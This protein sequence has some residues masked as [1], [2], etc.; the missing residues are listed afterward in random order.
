MS[1]FFEKTG[2][3]LLVALL[4]V[5]SLTVACIS[6][7]GVGMLLVSGQYEGRGSLADEL[8]EQQMQ[9]D[10]WSI[11][12][13][14]FDPNEPTKPWVSYY[15]GGIYT[16][17]NSNFRYNI[18]DDETGYSVLATVKGGESIRLKRQYHHSFENEYEITV[19]D[20]YTVRSDAISCEGTVYFY[21]EDQNYF[22]PVEDERVSQYVTGAV[23]LNAAVMDEG[24]TYLPAPEYT[25]T[26]G[27]VADVTTENGTYAHFAY[28]GYG[29]FAT[30]FASQYLNEVKDY[31]I[32]CYVLSDLSAP[33]SYWQIYDFA[34]YLTGGRYQLAAVCAVSLLAGVLL[35]ILLGCYVGRVAGAE[36]PV[37]NIIFRLPTDIL[38]L[39]DFLCAVVCVDMIVQ[40]VP[41][42]RFLSA[43]VAACVFLL[44]LALL[45]VYS[46]CSLSARGKTHTL[47]SGSAIYWCVKHVK[48]LAKWLG[49][50]AARVLG[51]MPLLWKVGVCYGVL[52]FIEFVWLVG[53]SYYVDGATV[54]M[55]LLERL[56]LGVL[57][58]YVTLAFRRLK[59][60]A[61]SIAAGDYTTKIS[62]AHLVLDFKETA[63]TLNHIQDGMNAAVDSRMKSERLKTELITNV[64]HDIKTPLTSIVSYVDLLKK[65]PMTTEAAKEYLSVLER[66]SARLKKLVEDL[67]EAS[68]ASTGNIAVHAESMDISVVLGQ[69]LGEYNERLLKIGLTPVV[70]VPETPVMVS[71][72][73]RLLW[74]VFDNLLGNAV[75]Y[76]MPGTRLYVTVSADSHAIVTMRN[77]SRDAL[78]IT[79]EE[80]KER[81][82]RGD[83]SRHTEGSGLGLSIAE[84]LVNS[85]GGE[86]LLS[87]DGDLFKVAVILPLLPEKT[88]SPDP[89]QSIEA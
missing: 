64:S 57:V 25:S 28:D 20:T 6:G 74:R 29:F 58:A 31:T 22:Y 69:A 80:L 65:E 10:A 33:D 9:K 42:T 14:Y 53:L 77:V 2:I 85:M 19:E 3:K 48:R 66:Q 75:K 70:K 81:F 49:R 8:A 41:T 26:G 55:W 83:A 63:D 61:Q 43:I 89:A 71:A 1:N 46:I 11:M 59:L 5:I 50:T 54:I 72:D 36:R 34:G 18:T 51:Y 87:V 17:E 78:D 12:N 79:A 24:F 39:G 44:L 40:L 27:T 52:C 84:S 76:A 47:I 56:A 4:C 45:A 37:L 67:V 62:E 86:F 35:L 7:I 38:L 16:G 82:V 60:G 21:D 30:E 13:G 68:K 32:T 23:K 73:G 15:S 88:P